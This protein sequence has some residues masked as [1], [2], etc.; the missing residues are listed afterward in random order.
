[1]PIYLY[2]RVD[3]SIHIPTFDCVFIGT[4]EPWQ[5]QE[6]DKV[7]Q[8]QEVVAKK[9]GC[10]KEGQTKTGTFNRSNLT[11]ASLEQTQMKSDSH[12]LLCVC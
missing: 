7:Y 9:T 8:R 11:S 10:K 6:E 4:L 2:R 3:S 12:T 5:Q 1:M